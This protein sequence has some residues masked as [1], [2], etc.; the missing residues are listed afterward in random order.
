MA[1][2]SPALRRLLAELKALPSDRLAGRLA[3]LESEPARSAQHASRT[4]AAPLQRILERRGIEALYTHQA[5]ALDALEAGQDVVLATGTNS[6]KSLVY[7]LA[8]AGRALE[9]PGA[10][11]LLLFPLKA[12]EQDQLAGLRSDLASLGGTPAGWAEIY[13]GDTPPSRRRKLRAEPPSALL[14]T[15][16]MLHAGILASHAQWERFFA[17]LE[18]VVIDEVHTYRGVFGAHLAQLIRRLRR[19]AAAYGAHPHFLSCSAT[20]GNP[21]SFVAALL[22][23]EPTVIDMDGA[24]RPSRPLA[25]IEPEGPASTTAARVFRLC[26]ARGLRT[27]AFTQSRRMTELMYSW[28]LD[29]DPDLAGRVSAYRSG[30]LPEERR[31]IESRLFSGQLSGVVTT[32]ALELG[33][34]VGGL[35]VCLLVGYPGSLLTTRQRAGRVGRGREGLVILVPHEDALDRYILHHPRVLIEGPCEEAVLD[36]D[37]REIV[38]AHL[39]CA[40]AERPLSWHERWLETP[41]VRRAV[42]EALRAGELLEST[43]SGELYAAAHRPWAQV[44]LRSIG[45]PF[46]IRRA[47][48]RRRRTLGTVGAGRVFAECHQGAIYLH[49]GRAYRVRRLDLERHEV[50]VEGPLC[51]DH[52][53]RAVTEKATEILEITQS[54]PLGN[55]VVRLGRLRITSRTT[56]YETRRVFGGDLLSRHPLE[57]PPQRFETEGLWIELAPQIEREV[58]REGGHFMGGIHGLE[59]AALALFPLL[60]LC[61][62]FDVAGISIPRHPQVE[63]PAVFLYDGQPGGI[64]LSRAVYPRADE[65][66]EMARLGVGGCRCESGCPACIHSPRCGA[67]NRPLD[68]AATVRTLDW[69][70]SDAPLPA[71]AERLEVDEP[72]PQP[73]AP[74]RSPPGVLVFDIETQRSAEEVGGWRNAQLMRVAIAVTW[75]CARGRFET[76]GEPEVETLIERLCEAPL[77]VG[78]NSLGFDYRVLAAYAARDLSGLPTLDLLEDIRRRIGHRLSL[79]HLARC[80]LG[81]GKSGDGLQSLEWYRR[82]EIDRV[83]RYCRDDVVLL[84][85]LLEFGAREGHVRYRHRSG[86]IVRLAVDWPVPGDVARLAGA[87]PSASLARHA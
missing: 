42:E 77:V 6:G 61:D 60:A 37:N 30:F 54:R 13:D 62:R 52:Y 58:A 65:L 7:S 51:T 29:A 63:G 36:P 38:R 1:P 15:P 81:R 79:D 80:T 74:P 66:L 22:G 11:S 18:L 23:R 46:T 45:Q 56:H 87:V 83:A 4:L 47:V 26:L 85:D 76:F 33:I 2:S 69:I 57:L 39:P 32:S 44:S 14:T 68:K 24:P 48:S 59:H 86:E 72:P 82:G 5:R 25:L 84:R 31:E 53:T 8:I 27:I 64:G 50:A 12:L 20:V 28:I 71:S 35:D 19:V 16:D 49:R 3:A 67:G 70:L 21:G 75:D 41:S 34:D 17:R 9:D 73:S 10:R 55:A 78:F 40:A 43:A